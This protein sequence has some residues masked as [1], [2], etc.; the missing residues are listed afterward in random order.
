MARFTIT[1]AA[2][3]N[4]GPVAVQ[5]EYYSLEEGWLHFK[6]EKGKHLCTIAAGTVWSI[7]RETH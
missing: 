5:A 1:Y 7:E 6:D 3:I 2:D 4:A